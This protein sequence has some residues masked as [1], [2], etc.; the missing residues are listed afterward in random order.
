MEVK[1]IELI[2]YFK[3]SLKKTPIFNKKKIKRTNKI[4]M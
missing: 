3:K 4:Y 2:F 1:K